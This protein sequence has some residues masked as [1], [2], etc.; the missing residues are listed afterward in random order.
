MDTGKFNIKTDFYSGYEGEPE[1][2]LEMENNFPSMKI[3]DGFLYDLFYVS[4]PPNGNFKGFTRDFFHDVG[5]WNDDWE[6]VKIENIDE[7]IED[8]KGYLDLKFDFPK[9]SEA[10]HALYDYLL[11]AKE[12]NYSVFVEID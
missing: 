5:I 7:Y 6:K 1:L 8:V 9:T 12:H 10:I 3:W 2:V 11:F 4:N